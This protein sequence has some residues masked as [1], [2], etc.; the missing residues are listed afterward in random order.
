MNLNI[1]LTPLRTAAAGMAVTAALLVVLLGGAYLRSRSTEELLSNTE[2]LQENFTRRKEADLEQIA[3][4]ESELTE[5]E[6]EIESLK[7]AFPEFGEPYAIYRQAQELAFQNQVTLL[8]INRAGTN[9][10]ETER[11]LII[12]TGYNIQLEGT[13]KTCLAYLQSLE[14][15]GLGLV[16]PEEILIIPTDENCELTARIFSLP[17]TPR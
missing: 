17:E 12:S 11:G 16:S 5:A 2:S 8:S 9:Q 14:D 4:L 13:M 1:K 3:A 10:L 15:D 6:A 7:N